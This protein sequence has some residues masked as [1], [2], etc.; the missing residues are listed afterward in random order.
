MT[1]TEDQ[2]CVVVTAPC[3]AGPTG[4]CANGK[5]Q[6]CEH[7]AGG[8]CSDGIVVPEG[9]LLTPPGKRWK[10]ASVLPDNLSSGHAGHAIIRPSHIY[11]CGCS[12]HASGAP[13]QLDL[14]GAAS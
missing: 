14:F 6:Q 4:H 3:M 7:R 2:R 10:G 11:R 5:H 1:L 8:A 9:F 12:C 13:G